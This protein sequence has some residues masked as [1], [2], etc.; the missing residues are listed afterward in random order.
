[1]GSRAEHAQLADWPV[2]HKAALMRQFDDWSTDRAIRLADLRRFV[3]DRS[4]IADAYLG[5][6]IVWESSGSSGEPAIFVQDAASLAVY[7]AIEA[8]RQHHPRPL[9]RWLDPWYCTERVAFIGATTGH[10]ASTV[11]MERLRRINPVLTHAI[12]H[13]SFLQSNAALARQL[14]RIEPTIIGTYPSTALLLAEERAAGRLRIAPREIRTGGETLTAQTRRFV[15]DTFGCAVIDSYGA[16]EFLTIACECR[17]RQLHL[18]SDWLILEPVDASGRPTEP[19]VAGSTVLLTNLAN[20]VQPLIRY[21]LGDRVA[22]DERRCACGSPLPV[23]QVKGRSDDMLR[24]EAGGQPA[25]SIAPLALCTVLEDDAGLY[26]FQLQQTAPGAL[27]L[28]T[29]QRGAAA[30]ATLRR[31]RHALAALLERQ[32]A[33]HVEIHTAT[34]RPHQ[35]GASGKVKRILAHAAPACGRST[36]RRGDR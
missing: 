32:G 1:M 33:G 36:A 19:G 22:V 14:E 27:L 17:H 9:H 15:Q 20:L 34:G 16:S 10:F 29:P 5:R 28:R 26:D 24:L 35:I 18:N 2:M 25:V 13:V 4:R 30:E 3:S 7:D 8:V 12:H 23:L 6:Y 21:D 31:G 11:S